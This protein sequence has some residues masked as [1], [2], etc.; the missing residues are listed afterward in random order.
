MP[1]SSN[2]SIVSQIQ[3]QT[4]RQHSKGN[5]SHNHQTM[6]TSINNDAT[7]T[8]K[9]AYT[10]DVQGKTK[11]DYGSRSMTCKGNVHE[12]AEGNKTEYLLISNKR[13]FL[14]IRNSLK[15][16]P[17]FFTGVIT[18]ARLD[19]GGHMMIN[20]LGVGV[21]LAR[22]ETTYG[23][24]CMIAGVEVIVGQST[25]NTYDMKMGY[26]EVQEAIYHVLEEPTYALLEAP[27]SDYED[28]D[29]A[30]DYDYADPSPVGSGTGSVAEL[31]EEAMQSPPDPLD[32]EITPR[33]AVPQEI[34]EMT[35]INHEILLPQ[36]EAAREQQHLNEMKDEFDTLFA[37]F[38]TVL[39][40][41]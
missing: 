35:A 7:K 11:L 33:R 10:L 27:E 30:D 23:A 28:L 8:Y 19:I 17:G 1:N 20:T 9:D 15:I 18:K 5:L 14:G 6:L 4:Y 31:V 16:G 21:G 32:E 2:S 41:S 36:S 3:G 26:S 25:I 39:T 38:A 24:S 13:I 34:I 12:Q 40:S 37:Q 22:S 29:S